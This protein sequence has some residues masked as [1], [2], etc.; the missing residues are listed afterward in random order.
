MKGHALI[1]EGA[2]HDDDGNSLLRRW[3]G[4]YGDGR[5]KC[6]CGEMSWW[7]TSSTKRKAWHREHK[8]RLRKESKA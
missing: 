6:T 8:E 7:L 4:T 2:P 1:G 3:G 5:A